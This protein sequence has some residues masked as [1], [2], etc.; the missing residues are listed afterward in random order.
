LC[1][2][3]P[4]R[5]NN[6]L[7]KQQKRDDGGKTDHM[8]VRIERIAFMTLVT[9]HGTMRIN[10]TTMTV[11]L[12]LDNRIYIASKTVS[13]LVALYSCHGFVYF[14]FTV[15]ALFPVSYYFL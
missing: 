1:F 2:G 6:G 13:L 5:C 15:T 7:G 11:P 9:N 10:A 3:K 8:G 14:F 12:S 4:R